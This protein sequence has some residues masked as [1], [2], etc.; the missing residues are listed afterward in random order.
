MLT[1][2]TC[3]CA[4]THTL[5]IEPEV[6]AVTCTLGVLYVAPMCSVTV[7]T[8]FS[9]P[10]LD[11]NEGKVSLSWWS[12]ERLRKW[13][14]YQASAVRFRRP[15]S[16]FLSVQ[17]KVGLPPLFCNRAQKGLELS[18]LVLGSASVRRA[19]P[20]REREEGSF[21]TFPQSLGLWELWNLLLHYIQGWDG[22]GWGRGANF[23][24]CKSCL[25]CL[26]GRGRQGI[27]LQVFVCKT[28]NKHR[29]LF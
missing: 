8:S 16:P 12:L 17:K 27:D 4:H 2:C 20:S 11:L 10:H 28:V 21:P 22:M 18:E 13:G 5:V 15:L 14:V 24:T 23:P 26:K 25:V 1:V 6:L 9:P 7:R 19:S 3:T 29:F